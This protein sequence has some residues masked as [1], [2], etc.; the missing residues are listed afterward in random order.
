MKL[1]TMTTVT[2]LSDPIIISEPTT[3]TIGDILNS[4]DG[5]AFE[6]AI[7][8]Y[9]KP[10]YQRAHQQSTDWCRRLCESVLKGWNIGCIII[11]QWIKLYQLEDDDNDLAV[12]TFFNIED[13][14]TR[15]DA[16]V[17][18]KNGEFV[19]AFGNYESL[20]SRFESYK[21]I[22]CLQKKAQPRVADRIYHRQLL[23]N[24]SLLQD[25]RPLSDSDRYFVWVED[26]I[27][28]ISGS[29]L[30]NNTL[31]LINVDFRT[32]FSE[33]ANL[34]VIDSRSGDNARK[35]LSEAIAVISACWKGPSYANKSYTR[36]IDV[37]NKP[38]TPEDIDQVNTFLQL[39]FA[40]IALNFQKFP[41]Y[42]NEA[43]K[44]VFL[45]TRTYIGTMITDLFDNP[46]QNTIDFINRWATLM[47][48]HRHMKFRETCDIANDWLHNKVYTGLSTDDLT[49]CG[50]KEYRLK[51]DAICSWWVNFTQEDYEYTMDDL[52]QDESDTESMNTDD[53]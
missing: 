34:N 21:L 39:I 12:E 17:R 16:F 38:F 30:V 47:S 46:E 28:G 9:R 11:S 3:L 27:N 15:I 23:E 43:C 37:L 25:G 53:E 2:A 51:R 35:P 13:G 45:G 42:K 49:R 48:I 52:E 6:N 22:V 24:F 50:S 26:D 44:K 19:T 32:S 29:P 1:A 4:Y 36:H 7:T 41:K 20:K 10:S 40:A 18:F 33:F 31:K 5:P 8:T 14:Q